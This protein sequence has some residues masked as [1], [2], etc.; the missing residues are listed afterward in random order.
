MR[1]RFVS[2]LLLAAAA[3]PLAAGAQGQLGSVKFPVT[4]NEPAQAHMHTAVAML[5][6]F[7]FTEARKTFESVVQA[8]S[9]CGIA[10]W[11]VALTHFGNPMAGGSTG[12]AQADGWKAAQKAAQIGGHSE[13][14]RAYIDAAVALYRDY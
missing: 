8:D 7:W 12:P 6:S 4:C 10:Y 14:D 13:R 1:I 9:T 3:A 11:G 5:H 2:L